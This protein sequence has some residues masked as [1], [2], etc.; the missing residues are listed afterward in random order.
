MKP[1]KWQ[2]PDIKPS[3]FTMLH[4]TEKH[5][6]P[7]QNAPNTRP[8]HLA[9]KKQPAIHKSVPASRFIQ[10]VSDATP[11]RQTFTMYTLS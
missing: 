7:S 2:P 11:E 10:P 6:S 1:T 5:E 8:K 3:A 4:Q 9:I